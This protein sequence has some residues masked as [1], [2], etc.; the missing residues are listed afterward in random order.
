MIITKILKN[1]C[2][3]HTKLDEIPIDKRNSVRFRFAIA[4][5]ANEK[6]SAYPGFGFDDF[7]LGRK[8]RN[9][10]IGKIYLFSK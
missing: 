6:N 4:S 3:P 9:E 5:D 2:M 10:Y 7:F 1:G 8:K